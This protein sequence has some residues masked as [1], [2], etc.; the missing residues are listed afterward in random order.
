[1]GKR[2]RSTKPTAPQETDSEHD[3]GGATDG[4]DDVIDTS[5]KNFSYEEED[6]FL[7]IL[8]RH[9]DEIEKKSTDKSL[10]PLKLKTA[11]QNTW[12]QI[13][14]EHKEKTGVSVL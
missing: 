11:Q 10:S 2:T 5:R 13:A 3:N 14:K 9:F 7:S 4:S 1:M 8:L 6:C 12:T